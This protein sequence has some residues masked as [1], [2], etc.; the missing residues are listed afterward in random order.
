LLV[1]NAPQKI[2]RDTYI[3]D[4]TTNS[5]NGGKVMVIAKVLERLGI[6]QSE[7]AR[8][9]GIDKY[10][11]CNY[12]TG[13]AIP[14]PSTLRRLSTGLRV[15]IEELK[16]LPPRPDVE[17]VADPERF[18]KEALA[19]YAYLHCLRT[20]Q[21]G[22]WIRKRYRILLESKPTTAEMLKRDAATCHELREEIE[23]KYA[24]EPII[25]GRATLTNVRQALARIVEIHEPNP[26][27]QG[28]W[29]SRMLGWFC[30]Y[31]E[32]PIENEYAPGWQKA[33]DCLKADWKWP[34]P[35]EDAAK[36][37]RL[38]QDAID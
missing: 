1:L 16:G 3:A 28:H 10:R 26:E 20:D 33:M 29:I 22:A 19:R 37:A 7:A 2:Q 27:N 12:C 38:P 15:T 23:A 6:S 8:R 17:P 14:G 25:E 9:T 24:P 36:Q 31:C 13:A 4:K 21:R 5:N 30:R 18:L 34:T 32:T 35:A 11:I